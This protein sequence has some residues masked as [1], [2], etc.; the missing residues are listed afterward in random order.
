MDGEAYIE[1][2][3]SSFYAHIEDITMEMTLPSGWSMIS[4]P[5]TPDDSSAAALFPGAAVIYR[6]E[7]SER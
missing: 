4:L 6:H 5:V 7:S 1:W 3:S 2:V